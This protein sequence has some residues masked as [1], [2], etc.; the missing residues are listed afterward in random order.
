MPVRQ[1]VTTLT[2]TVAIL[3]GNTF[4]DTAKEDVIAAAKPRA[5]TDLIIK[6]RVIKLAPAGARSSNL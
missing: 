2:K 3:F 5:S 4:A 6:H 1:A